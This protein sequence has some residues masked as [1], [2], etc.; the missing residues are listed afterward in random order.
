ML[1]NLKSWEILRYSTTKCHWSLRWILAEDIPFPNET[2][3][4]PGTCS[5][6]SRRSA[7]CFFTRTAGFV[8]EILAQWEIHQRLQHFGN[9]ILF[10]MSCLCRC[11]T[12]EFTFE[13]GVRATHLSTHSM[14][15]NP[16]FWLLLGCF[17]RSISC[18]MCCLVPHGHTAPP[19]VADLMLAWSVS[20]SGNLR[21][22]AGTAAA[23]IGPFCRICVPCWCHEIFCWR[24]WCVKLPVFLG[25]FFGVLH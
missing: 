6:C 12:S 17:Y 1:S 8:S 2:Q 4:G 7:R 19:Q 25:F 23:E 21:N 11:K 15:S 18:H 10:S 9:S 20:N 22:K 3:L 24:C 13:G 14:I 16:Y 5:H